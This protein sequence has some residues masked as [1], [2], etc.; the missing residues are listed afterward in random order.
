[1][2]ITNKLAKREWEIISEKNLVYVAWTRAKKTLN[3]VSEKEFPPEKSYSG[4]DTL[5]NEFLNIKKDVEEK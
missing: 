4:N 5:Y 1:M 2:K 3:F